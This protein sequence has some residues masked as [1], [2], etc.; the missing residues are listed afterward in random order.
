MLLIKNQFMNTVLYC[1]I[2]PLFLWSFGKR[3]LFIITDLKDKNYSRLK[4]DLLYALIILA[5][6]A[7]LLWISLTQNYS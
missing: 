6:M 1:I 2:I 3:V 4:V 7:G 5:V